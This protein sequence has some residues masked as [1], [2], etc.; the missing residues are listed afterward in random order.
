[1]KVLWFLFTYWRS[2]DIAE[3]FEGTCKINLE[4]AHASLQP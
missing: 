3:S 4:E 1:M 2:A